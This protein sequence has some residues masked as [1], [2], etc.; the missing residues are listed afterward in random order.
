MLSFSA[1]ILEPSASVNSQ[2]RKSL[3]AFWSPSAAWELI[4]R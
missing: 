3:V 2:V 4:V 1:A